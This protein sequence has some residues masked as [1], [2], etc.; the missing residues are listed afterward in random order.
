MVDR[1]KR[2]ILAY[3]SAIWAAPICFTIISCLGFILGLWYM[4]Q[5]DSENARR[6]G[7]MI[8]GLI[9]VPV[10]LWAWL[11]YFPKPPEDSEMLRRDYLSQPGGY[12][13]DPV[14]Q[15]IWFSGGCGFLLLLI[16]GIWS[17]VRTIYGL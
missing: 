17:F 8:I 9:A 16:L 3:Y 13:T 15:L 4:D 12:F 7:I 2:A 1:K 6:Y 11:G 10:W 5:G 14:R